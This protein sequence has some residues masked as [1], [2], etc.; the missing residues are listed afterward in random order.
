MF[1]G[2]VLNLAMLKTPYYFTDPR[3]KTKALKLQDIANAIIEK[4]EI[5]VE[6]EQCLSSGGSNTKFNFFVRDEQDDRVILLQTNFEIPFLAK[7]E[8]IEAY[9]EYIYTNFHI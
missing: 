2:P 8:I 5:K 3:Y 6:I 7:E 4:H 1:I 9:Y